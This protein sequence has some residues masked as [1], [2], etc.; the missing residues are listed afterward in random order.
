MKKAL[1][2]VYSDYKPNLKSRGYWKE[3][4][5]QRKFFDELA[6]KWNI[7]K[8]DDWSKV[9]FDMVLKEG[10]YFIGKYYHSSL[11]QGT[12]MSWKL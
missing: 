9:N 4:E 2:A 10:G 6:I 7:Q 3:K 1:Q 8:R 11:Q 5:N 12:T